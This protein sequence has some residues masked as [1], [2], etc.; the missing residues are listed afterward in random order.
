MG[1]IGDI[2]K[3]NPDKLK[4]IF[5]KWG[6]YLYQHAHG[7]DDSEVEEREEAKSVGREVTFEQDTGDFSLL[8]QVLDEISEDVYKAT[9]AEG[10]AF[11]TIVLKIR[12][13]GFETHTKQK[14]IKTEVDLDKVRE[15]AGELLSHF[16]KSKKKIRLIGLRLTN[17]T[18]VKK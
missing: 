8:K 15:I 5:G 12:F 13:E 16:S 10:Y 3:A 14:S 1:K 11:R 9:K 18:K 2:A 7:I 4:E 17:L 6:H